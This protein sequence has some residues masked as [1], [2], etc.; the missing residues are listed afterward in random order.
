[1]NHKPKLA[2]ASALCAG[3]AGITGFFA[4]DAGSSHETTRQTAFQVSTSHSIE[5][6][7][8]RT[9]TSDF[10]VLREHRQSKDAGTSLDQPVPSGLRQLAFSFGLDIADA[11]TVQTANG[12]IEIVPGTTD[13]CLINS[14]DWGCVRSTTA[15]SGGLWH[16]GPMDGLDD[17]SPTETLFG[18]A[19]DGNSSITVKWLDGTSSTVPTFDNTYEIP[20][21]TKTGFASISMLN[22]AG[23]P[24][25]VQGSGDITPH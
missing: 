19:P 15:E 11:M 1:M 4:I 14:G 8:L 24:V 6:R 10:A 9:V 20:L 5:S 13:M 3:L 17:A 2:L 12:P 16:I 23:S 21:G 22:A 18:V 25:L 7:A